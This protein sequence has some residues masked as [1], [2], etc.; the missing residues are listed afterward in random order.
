MGTKAGLGR[1]DIGFKAPLIRIPSQRLCHLIPLLFLL[2]V[3]TLVR[4]LGTLRTRYFSLYS[5]VRCRI[6]AICVVGAAT[7]FL[8]IAI[9]LIYSLFTAQFTRFKEQSLLDDTVWYPFFI[10][11]FS[12]FS[13]AI[14]LLAFQLFLTA[15]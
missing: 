8:R 3:W 9:Q 11:G 4:L 2:F 5:K 14:P 10:V 1:N 6:I 13:E 7:L 12:V 15:S